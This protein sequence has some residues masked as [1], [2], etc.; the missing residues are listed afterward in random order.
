MVLNTLTTHARAHA[1]LPKLINSSTDMLVKEKSVTSGGWLEKSTGTL[2][3]SC[4]SEHDEH[5]KVKPSK[6]GETSTNNV[7]NAQAKKSSTQ[8]T[9]KEPRRKCR[10]KLGTKKEQ[11]REKYRCCWIDEYSRD[12][13][14]TPHS[15]M[16]NIERHIWTQ[17]LQSSKA[18]CAKMGI[19]EPIRAIRQYAVS[20]HKQYVCKYLEAVAESAPKA[21]SR[22]RLGHRQS[23]WLG[24]LVPSYERSK[25]N[26]SI[27]SHT[28]SNQHLAGNETR[29]TRN[30]H[31]HS[32]PLI[33][34]EESLLMSSFGRMST[35]ASAL[36]PATTQDIPSTD[37]DTRSPSPVTLS[38]CE[39]VHEMIQSPLHVSS[40]GPLNDGQSNN[41]EDSR[42][43]NYSNDRLSHTKAPARLSSRTDHEST[44]SHP[45]I[46]TYMH[47]STSA[48]VRNLQ[49]R[50]ESASD[51][52]ST[53]S[54]NSMT[55]GVYMNVHV[56][57]NRR[58]SI[59]K[60]KNA[61]AQPN[62]QSF[63]LPQVHTNARSRP[64]S[65]IGNDCPYYSNPT[66]NSIQCDKRVEGA[67]MGMN[68]GMGGVVRRQ[69]RS[70]GGL[71][72]RA[73]PASLYGISP[74]PSS[75][76]LATVHCEDFLQARPIS[77][78][79]GNIGNNG[80]WDSPVEQGHS[81]KPHSSSQTTL[82][83][84]SSHWR[85]W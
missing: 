38:T 7:P 25:S 80:Q 51:R 44:P 32:T 63:Y 10:T 57:A 21:S 82:T 4:G 53:D 43:F 64:H 56:R 3:A 84:S 16:N 48:S 74:G 47:T 85:P 71:K 24:K 76:T 67:D 58:A 19:P 5:D 39:Q 46:N 40:P 70:A 6:D 79:F 2:V 12:V 33:P 15:K 49:A 28:L 11:P 69:A 54:L 1:A 62:H 9:H 18:I 83:T 20:V 77:T 72:I 36:A 50:S 35:S 66:V 8:V 30:S 45:Y 68:S 78:Y 59:T 55:T 81:P 52:S 65:M 26:K 22:S 17:H 31:S 37:V 42:I 41:H 23:K 34:R 75:S 14:T 13:C 73:R 60:E 61:T 27:D 29:H